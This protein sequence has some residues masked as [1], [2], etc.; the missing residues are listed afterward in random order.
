MVFKER[1]EPNQAD[2]EQSMKNNMEKVN[3]DHRG[4]YATKDLLTVSTIDSSGK[5][6]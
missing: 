5:S 6:E 2:D 4:C 3:C 1:E